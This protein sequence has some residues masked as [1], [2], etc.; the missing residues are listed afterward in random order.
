MHFLLLLILLCCSNFVAADPIRI[1]AA[2]N[3]YGSVAKQIGGNYV[4]VYNILNNP[5]QDPHLFSAS[6]E[7]AKSLAK[8]DIV[9][10]NGAGYDAWINRLLSVNTKKPQLIVI[11]ELLHKKNAINPHFW[12]DPQTM[13]VYVQTLT[14]VLSQQD[15]VHK[16]YYVAQQQKFMQEYQTL[17]RTIRNMK[18]HYE[19]TPVI[20]TEPIFNYMTEALGLKMLGEKFQINIMNDVEPTASQVKSFENDL[21]HHEAKVLIYN[22]QVIN[23]HTQYMEALAKKM[24]IPVVGV[25]EML[26]AE[27]TYIQLMQY[28]LKQLEQ[29]L[30][31]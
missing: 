12:Y 29:A 15:P 21:R 4:E 10:A 23:P 19:N 27:K 16:D 24:N 9:V 7:T 20:A 30:R 22:Q 6:H 3:I 28:E 13:P 1:V 31:V 18:A 5:N 8:A 26:P 2:E 11:A 17:I 25:K 14:N